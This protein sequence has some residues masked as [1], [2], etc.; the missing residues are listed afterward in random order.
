[1]K[2]DI[3]WTW[4]GTL[5]RA[6][7]PGA[8]F[9]V[10]P[11]YGPGP[12]TYTIFNNTDVDFS[13]I[14][15]EV[16][17]FSSYVPLEAMHFLPGDIGPPSPDIIALPAGGTYSID[18]IPP[19]GPYYVLAQGNIVGPEGD[20][21]THFVQQH[22]HPVSLATF[23]VRHNMDDYIPTQGSPVG[24]SWMSLYPATGE[25]CQ[26]IDWHD[27]GDE[28]LSYCDNIQL[29]NEELMA[30]VWEH[31]ERITPTIEIIGPDPDLALYLESI[32]DNETIEPISKPIGTMWHEVFPD[33]CRLFLVEA[34]ENNGTS[35]LDSG[36]FILMQLLSGP[37][38]GQTI[39]YT[40]WD[41]ATDIISDPI[42][43]CSGTCGDAN[44]D[45]IADVSD[46]VW[47]INYV[48]VGGEPPQPVLAC[49]DANGDATVDISDAVWLIN[50]I[51]VGGETP[52]NCSP[53]AWG[54]SGGDCCPFTD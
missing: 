52:G 14:D 30:S 28:I 45:G 1:M 44:D 3:N 7:L 43:P 39:G 27:N 23:A 15:L 50:Y 12:V 53:G 19:D 4:N 21:T 35:I 42:R 20:T 10:E 40:V 2:R 8:G 9:S 47:V 16:G 17:I 24:T 48:F 33:H 11:P 32:A 22:E 34:W 13:V 25:I 29:Y 18:L 26:I 38:S 36:D 41:Y 54:T 51:F 5:I 46:A 31:I 49:G 37:H 6:E